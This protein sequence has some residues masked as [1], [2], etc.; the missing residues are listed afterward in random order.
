MHNRGWEYGSG[1]FDAIDFTP[2]HDVILSG[3]RLWGVR[4]RS[5]TYRVIS[6]LYNQN[7][8]LEQKT[9]S[10]FSQSSKKKTFPVYFSRPVQ[11]RGGV[12]YTVAA[13]LTGTNTY[14]NLSEGRQTVQCGG[15]K[16]SFKT[17]AGKG[18]MSCCNGS[19]VNDGQIPALIFHVTGQ[20]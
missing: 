9:G 18:R 2:D 11:L 13:K 19:S 16:V 3:Y 6:R 14:A 8:L 10:Y 4:S 5:H 17:S 20:C 7:Q 1:Q 15:V 12:T